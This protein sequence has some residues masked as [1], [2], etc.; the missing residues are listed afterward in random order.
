[1]CTQR[2]SEI[3][4]EQL[5]NLDTGQFGSHSKCQLLLSGYF[6]KCLLKVRFWANGQ[7]ASDGLQEVAEFSSTKLLESELKNKVR[8]TDFLSQ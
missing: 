4:L 6:S 2:N 5:I 1:M 7:T 3:L 8:K